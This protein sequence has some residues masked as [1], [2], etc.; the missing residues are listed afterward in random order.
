MSASTA[1]VIFS[2]HV[3]SARDLVHDFWQIAEPVLLDKYW[4]GVAAA[5]GRHAEARLIF[6]SAALLVR[7]ECKQSES[8]I[9][10]DKL[11]LTEKTRNLWENDVCEAFIAPDPEIPEKY[12]E[13]EA[14]PTGEWLDLKIHQQTGKRETDWGYDSGME[15]AAEVRPDSFII[16]MRLPWEAFGKRPVAGDK[17]RGNLFRCVGSGPDRGYLAWQPTFTPEPNF[18]VPKAFGSFEFVK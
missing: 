13:F 5:N 7:F 18:H 15:T 1:K 11:F 9:I 3:I 14:A 12:L 4:S 17:W 2:S 6:T 8:L 10:N 16:A